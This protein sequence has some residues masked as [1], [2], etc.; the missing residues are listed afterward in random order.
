[1]YKGP[2]NLQKTFTALYRGMKV[3]IVL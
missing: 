3:A 1:M 2:V